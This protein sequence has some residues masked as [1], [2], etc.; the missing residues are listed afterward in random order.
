MF[1]LDPQLE[2]DTFFIGKTPLNRILLMNDSRFPWLIL[3]PQRPGITEPF[4]LPE[5]EQRALWQES[6]ILGKVMKGFFNAQKLNVAALGNQVSQ[7]HIHHVARFQADA[8][9]PRPVWGV[10]VAEPYDSDAL[11]ER[12]SSLRDA[13]SHQL[14]LESL[15]S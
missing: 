13:L 2:A 8:A 3:V 4:D 12:V 10:G 14:G 7:L 6:M 9:W 15:V 1:E 11:R 5:E